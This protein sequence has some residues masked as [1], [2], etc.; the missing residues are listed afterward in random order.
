METVVSAHTGTI[1]DDQ[2]TPAPEDASLIFRPASY[3]EPIRWSEVFTR[4]NPVEVELGSG[5]GSFLIRQTAAHPNRNFIGVERFLGRIRK[6]DRKGRRAH[7]RNLRLFRIEAAYFVEYLIPPGSVTT[8]HIYFPDPWP[9]RRHHRHRLLNDRFPEIAAR[10]MEPGGNLFVRTDNIPY[11]NQCL[12]VFA[13]S[14]Q[15]RQIPTPEPL[16]A[17]VTDFERDFHARH[18]PTL[19]TAYTRLRLRCH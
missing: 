7:L 13:A 17:N 12:A 19:H 11:F 1:P 5:D 6:I 14:N 16:A 15:W 3:F 4:E 10:A 8:M 2:V 18:I 9:K